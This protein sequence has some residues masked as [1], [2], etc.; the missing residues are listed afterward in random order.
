[1]AIVGGHGVGRH[2]RQRRTATS[3]SGARAT[4][5]STGGGGDDHLGG[6]PGDDRL[7]RRRRSGHAR[8]RRRRRHVDGGAGVD[9][10][11]GDEV[12]ACIAYSCASGQDRIDARDG[13]RE[14]INCGPGTDTLKGDANDIAENWVDLSDECESVDGLAA[15]AGT[16]APAATF[17]L[18]SAKADA[19][20]AGHRARH[21]PGPGKVTVRAPGLRAS[22]TVR[23]AGSVKLRLKPSRRARL[24]LKITFTPSG[25]KPVTLTKTVRLRD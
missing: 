13:E 24:K 7:T 10:Y 4:T 3:W 25:G 18:V 16:A 22:R 20:P 2:H 11:W 9:R 21:R 12:G 1:M 5:S 15:A 6:G 8:R 17:K 14:E 19:Q 23:A